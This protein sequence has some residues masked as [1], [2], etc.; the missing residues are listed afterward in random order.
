M[1]LKT[2]KSLW[3]NFLLKTFFVIDWLHRSPKYFFSGN[4]IRSNGLTALGLDGLQRALLQRLQN[5]PRPICNSTQWASFW[6]EASDPLKSQ[7]SA[8]KLHA[9]KR[10]HSYPF[11]G[12]SARWF[13]K[14]RSHSHRRC[15][16]LRLRH[17]DAVEFISERVLEIGLYRRCSAKTE[18]AVDIK[19]DEIFFIVTT[20]GTAG[21]QQVAARGAAKH[22]PT[23]QPAITEPRAYLLGPHKI[24]GEKTI[25]EDDKGNWH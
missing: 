10:S 5:F 6:F 12:K 3:S 23:G 16:F 20:W 24:H 14:T 19:N 25:M 18:F 22:S 4:S 1:T 9:W 21:T 17:Q 15:L 11:T 2:E 13:V 7:S 8:G